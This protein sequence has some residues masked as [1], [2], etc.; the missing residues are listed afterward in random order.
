MLTLHTCAH[1]WKHTDEQTNRQTDRQ[2][3]IQTFGRTKPNE[4]T[5]MVVT[6]TQPDNAMFIGVGRFSY[7]THSV[8]FTLLSLTCCKYLLVL[9]LSLSAFLRRCHVCQLAFVFAPNVSFS[10][11]HRFFFFLIVC[12]FW[13]AV[14]FDFRKDLPQPQVSILIN[15]KNKRFEYLCLARVVFQYFND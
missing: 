14:I 11:S 8:V 12:N 5:W 2:R 13:G 9:V 15:K 3:D 1:S 4:P 6:H 7:H 10:S